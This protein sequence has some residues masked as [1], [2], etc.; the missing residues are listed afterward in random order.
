MRGCDVLTRYYI[1]EPTLMERV[2][3]LRMFNAGIALATR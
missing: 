3:A 2:E 1:D